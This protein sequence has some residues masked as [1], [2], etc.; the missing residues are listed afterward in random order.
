MPRKP[1]TRARVIADHGPLKHR[2]LAK[3][4]DKVN[5]EPATFGELDT[6][7]IH[8]SVFFLYAAWLQDLGRNDADNKPLGKI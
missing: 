7:V 3:G 5:R 8:F 1:R 4:P 2:C 6:E